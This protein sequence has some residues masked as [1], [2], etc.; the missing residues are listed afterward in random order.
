MHS[1]FFI[2]INFHFDKSR[3]IS[4]VQHE[5]RRHPRLD[6]AIMVQIVQGDLETEGLTRDISM[7]GMQLRLA[8]PLDRHDEVAMKILLPYE[9][10]EEYGQQSPLELKGVVK[11]TH[12]DSK[13]HYYGIQF[14]GIEYE[15]QRLLKHAFEF[16][17]TN[18]EFYAD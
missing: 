6:N 18:A 16:F 11:R 17:N 4:Q 9:D 13:Y 1:I 10:V 5:K 15:Q 8:S 2:K 3:T 14:T 7:S 12:R